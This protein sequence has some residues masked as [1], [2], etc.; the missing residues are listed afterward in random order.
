MS[1]VGVIS[2]LVKTGAVFGLLA[3]TVRLLRRIDGGRGRTGR[4][5]RNSGRGAPGPLARLLGGGGTRRRDPLLEI[6]ERKTLGRASSVV[7]LRVQD[8]HWVVGVTDQAV[9]VLLEVDVPADG[10]DSPHA[11]D[12]PHNADSADSADSADRIGN[13]DRAGTSV[14]DLRSGFRGARKHDGLAVTN[15]ATGDNAAAPRVPTWAGEPLWIADAQR[16]WRRLTRRERTEPVE[17]PLTMTAGQS[18]VPPADFATEMAL[19]LS[20][21][22][23][24]AADSTPTGP[25]RWSG[26]SGEEHQAGAT[27]TTDGPSGLAPN[28]HDLAAST[29]RPQ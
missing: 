28:G 14:V 23:A 29:Q 6:V 19:Q 4:S 10:A 3:I 15:P 26:T 24:V 21:Q 2:V 1:M 13:A 5:R 8:Q 17:V 20:A 25:A 27:A 16:L 18:D 11:A 7:L 9:S 12:G 22:T